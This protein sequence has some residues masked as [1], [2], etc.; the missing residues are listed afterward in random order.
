M[1]A[2]LPQ[3]ILAAA[4]SINGP[5]VDGWVIP[6]QLDQL[7]ASRRFHDV[8]LLLG[9]NGDEGTPYP[10]FAT[11]LA[12]Y[13]AAANTRRCRSSACRWALRC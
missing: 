13:N 7:F 5:I 12:G 10:P 9:W 1:R 8:P 2:R 3:D 11:T 4:G 6:G